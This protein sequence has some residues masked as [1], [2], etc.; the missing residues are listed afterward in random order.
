M[1]V[2][3]DPD[4]VHLVQVTGVV[5]VGDT[6]E[7]FAAFM[8]KERERLGAVIAKSGIVMTEWPAS[9]DT[10]TAQLRARPIQNAGVAVTYMCSLFAASQESV[11]RGEMADSAWHPALRL[12]SS[13]KRVKERDQFVTSLR[14]AR[15][16]KGLANNAN[17]LFDLVGRVGIEPT[18]NGLRV[19]CSTS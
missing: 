2:M 13:T 1:K 16:D 4:T 17:P 11:T 7:A 10:F 8:A 9:R 14:T 12:A 3:H 6:P 18:T 15:N 5:P 19:R